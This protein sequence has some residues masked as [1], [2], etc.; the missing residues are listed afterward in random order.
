MGEISLEESPGKE[1]EVV[2]G[3]ALCRKEGDIGSTGEKKERKSVVRRT[4]WEGRISS[5]TDASL[6]PR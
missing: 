4:V 5:Y 3:R 2:W 6:G 1:I